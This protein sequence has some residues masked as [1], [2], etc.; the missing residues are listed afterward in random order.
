MKMKKNGAGIGE[1]QGQRERKKLEGKIRDIRGAYRQN[2]NADS[3]Q[4]RVIGGEEGKRGLEQ[5]ARRGY[6]MEIWEGR[7]ECWP[8]VKA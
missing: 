2:K 4:V 3:I 7:D 1:K 6:P 8:E 5:Q